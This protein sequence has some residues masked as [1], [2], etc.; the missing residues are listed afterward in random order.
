MNLFFRAH[1]LNKVYDDTEEVGEIHDEKNVVLAKV[2][3]YKCFQDIAYEVR[4][5]TE[6]YPNDVSRYN[7][8]LIGIYTNEE[9]LLGGVKRF[10][11]KV[12]EENREVM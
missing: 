6:S 7:D 8:K 4:T 3:S 9:E 12:T 11:D 10:Y 1:E 5:T 2:Y